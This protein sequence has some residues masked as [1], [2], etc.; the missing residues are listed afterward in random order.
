[1]GHEC[2]ECKFV[3]SRESIFVDR[4]TRERAGYKPSY[5][6]TFTLPN[7]SGHLKFYLCRCACSRAFV[8]YPHG[9][10]EGGY[11]FFFCD[12]CEAIVLVQDNKIYKE[13]GIERPSLSRTLWAVLQSKFSRRQNNKPE[14]AR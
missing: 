6:G 7:W 2:S 8:D 5:V 14:G 10:T 1:M 9:Y 12:S 11:L 4:K 13:S 3:A